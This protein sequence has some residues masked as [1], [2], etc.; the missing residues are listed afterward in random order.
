M[1]VTPEATRHGGAPSAREAIEISAATRQAVQKAAKK[2]G[3][4]AGQW[5]EKTL[6]KASRNVL[7]GGPSVVALPDELLD[8]LSD[9]SKKITKL[10]EHQTLDVKVVNQLETSVAELKPRVAAAMDQLKKFTN[11]MVDQAVSASEKAIS[12]ASKTATTT[13]QTLSK[14][15]RTS[16]RKGRKKR[17]RPKRGAKRT[18]SVRG[19]KGSSRKRKSSGRKRG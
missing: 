12:Q 5:I 13:L 19:G 4:P 10:A 9:I 6:Q 2:Q 11:D 17:A 7:M 14:R 18:G 15:V 1:G 8:T 16:A 3:I